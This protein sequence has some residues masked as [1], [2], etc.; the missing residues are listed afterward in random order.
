MATQNYIYGYTI[1]EAGPHFDPRTP[2]L[3]QQY[4]PLSPMPDAS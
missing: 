4:T 2:F 1:Y 3:L